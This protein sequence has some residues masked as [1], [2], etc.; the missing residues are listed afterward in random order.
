MVEI[1]GRRNAGRSLRAEIALDGE[2]WRWTLTVG[3]TSLFNGNWAT[4][5]KREEKEAAPTTAWREVCRFDDRQVHH[6]EYER[7]LSGGIRHQRQVTLCPRDQ[8][9]VIAE[10]LL[11]QRVTS[12][13]YE[14]QL[15]LSP[16][17]GVR[18][19]GETRELEVVI[20][21][22]GGVVLPLLLPEWKVPGQTP[23][24]LHEEPHLTARYATTGRGFFFPLCVAFWKQD[25]TSEAD[26]RKVSSSPDLR[27]PSL[28]WRQLTVSEC[29]RKVAP[30]EAVGFRIQVENRQ[31]LLYRS[32][33][34]PANRAVLGHN[35]ISESLLARFNP[36]GQVMPLVEVE[37][38]EESESVN[39][40]MDNTGTV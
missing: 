25:G 23:G 30:D 7:R 10:T 31:W 35:L 29:L 6:R 5:V 20:G 21:D 17:V 16:D 3:N 36:R 34:R 39:G 8:L 28:T 11:G 15:G 22:F 37:L 13:H 19:L 1:L 33:T 18:S 27:R 32:L 9:I 14:T 4:S 26:V 12:W 38:D 2:A 40:Q 24:L